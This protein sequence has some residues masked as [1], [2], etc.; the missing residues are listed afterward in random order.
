M[1]DIKKLVLREIAGF[2]LLSQDDCLSWMV[3]VPVMI[4]KL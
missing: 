1:D 4:S 3:S 2:A